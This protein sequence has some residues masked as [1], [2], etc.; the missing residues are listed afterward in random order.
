MAVFIGRKHFFKYLFASSSACGKWCFLFWMLCWHVCL[1]FKSILLFISSLH[2][3]DDLLSW[4][5]IRYL[6]V[7]KFEYCPEASRSLLRVT[8]NH[9]QKSK[10]V[11]LTSYIKRTSCGKR[12]P[13]A[14]TGF[15]SCK[16]QKNE[17]TSK[18]LRKTDFNFIQD[19]K[20]WAISK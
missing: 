7:P 14:V 1:F 13:S 12:N 3:I 5:Q 15:E 11:F 2:W 9:V 10:N 4:C 17:W 8:E 20:N 19:H 18:L 6:L 16:Y